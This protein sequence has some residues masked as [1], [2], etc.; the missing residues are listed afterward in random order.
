MSALD[1]E[2]RIS[3]LKTLRE[4]AGLGLREV[5]RELGVLHT[6]VFHWEKTGKIPD[7][8]MIM[9]MAD[10]YCVPVEKILGH[11]PVKPAIAPNSKMAKLFAEAATLPRPQQKRVAEFLEDMLAAQRAKAS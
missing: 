3:H 9:K 10:L 7:P 2:S 6:K 1:S 5:A 8:D 11:D 4:E